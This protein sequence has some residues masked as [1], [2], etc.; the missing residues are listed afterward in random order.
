MAK[1]L[2]RA[3]RTAESARADLLRALAASWES[4]TAE[5]AKA[6]VVGQPLVTDALTDAQLAQLKENVRDAVSRGTSRIPTLF[7]ATLDINALVASVPKTTGSVRIN[8]KGSYPSSP[9][10]ELAVEF[11]NLLATAGYRMDGLKNTTR[12]VSYSY[13]SFTADDV[14]LSAP[15]ELRRFKEAIE[16]IAEVMHEIAEAQSDEAAE[17]SARRWDTI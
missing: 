8:L 16:D 13:D 15:E 9:P 14:N 5:M 4:R 3:T 6:A 17:R 12:S 2:E 10:E 1:R 7:A 11:H